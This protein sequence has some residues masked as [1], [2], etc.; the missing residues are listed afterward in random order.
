VQDLV[1]RCARL[2]RGVR[3]GFIEI[4]SAPSLPRCRALAICR[5]SSP[6]V[7][8]S[9]NAAKRFHPSTTPWDGTLA[10]IFLLPPI[11]NPRLQKGSPCGGEGSIRVATFRRNCSPVYSLASPHWI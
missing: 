4:A 10:A 1:I 11:K 6:P 9:Y 8:P 7:A 2:E 3:S 5:R